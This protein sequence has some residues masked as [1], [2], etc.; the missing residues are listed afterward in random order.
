MSTTIRIQESTK[1]R[2]EKELQVRETMDQLLIR[3]LD[4][5]EELR[6]N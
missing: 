1:A 6:E 5:L 2:Y 4:E 3:L